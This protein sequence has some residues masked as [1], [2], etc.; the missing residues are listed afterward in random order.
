MRIWCR[1]ALRLF[2]GRVYCFKKSLGAEGGACYYVHFRVVFLYYPVYHANGK[3]ELFIILA[4]MLRY[5]YGVYLSL[6]YRHLYPHIAAVAVAL[7]LVNTVN[8]FC[9][10]KP[11]LLRCQGFLFLFSAFFLCLYLCLDSGSP[12]GSCRC[13]RLVRAET[14]QNK[15]QRN[16]LYYHSRIFQKITP[17][18]F[19][20]SKRIRYGTEHRI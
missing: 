1:V 6:L 17:L 14:P 11:C 13:D 8:V 4:G 5:F 9:S 20:L 15:K 3:T 16:K 18:P 7:A 19:S 10:R 2:K 12:V